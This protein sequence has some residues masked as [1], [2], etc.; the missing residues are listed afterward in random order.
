MRFNDMTRSAARPLLPCYF[1]VDSQVGIHVMHPQ[2]RCILHVNPQYL[3]GLSMARHG[4]L[5]L[6]H[7]NSLA[8]CDRIAYDEVHN[9]PVL[10]DDEGVRIAR[11]LGDKTILLMA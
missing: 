8:L 11:L 10:D 5:E 7:Q 4:R 9:G 6:A 2:G 1:A 3:T